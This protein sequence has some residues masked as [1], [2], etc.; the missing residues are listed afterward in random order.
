RAGAGLLGLLTKDPADWFAGN[1]DGE[2]GAG[3]AAVEIDALLERREALRRERNF[4]AADA[5]RDQLAE[6]GILVEDVAGG[7]RWRRAR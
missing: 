6:A 4:A 5:I 7:S 3:L 2:R 1:S